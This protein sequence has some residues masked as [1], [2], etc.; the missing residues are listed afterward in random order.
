MASPLL[1]WLF[2]FAVLV[3]NAEEALLL[4]EWSRRSGRWRRPVEGGPF[5]F[6]VTVLSLLLVVVAA[7]AALSRPRTL[8][9]YLLCGYAFAM[10]VNALVPHLAAT[11]A[12]RRYMPGTA[13]GLL[14]NLPLAL[15]LLRQ[16]WRSGW[17]EH[18]TLVWAA[19]V[20]ALALLAAIPLLFAIG[21]GLTR[22]SSP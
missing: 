20:V 7:A 16:A 5:R 18:G 4:P 17:V 6:A 8:P 1:L 14:L 15:L 2:T 3:H 11:V 9:A 12:L 19:P 22:G 21:R 10:A 13:T